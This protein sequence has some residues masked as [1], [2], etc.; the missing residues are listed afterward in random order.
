METNVL[1]RLVRRLKLIGIDVTMTSN[2][3][4]IY[5]DTVN[6]KK[7]TEKFFAK[8]GFTISFYPIRTGQEMKLFCSSK[9]FKIIRK[10]K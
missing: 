5:L 9:L 2:F 4:W 3:P 7:I 10:Y 1:D 8:H 6:G